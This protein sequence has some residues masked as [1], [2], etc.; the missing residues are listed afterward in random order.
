M[1]GDVASQNIVGYNTVG[2][3]G[4]KNPGIGA[5]FIPV[6]AT[7][8]D[9]TTYKLKDIT[10]S[11]G[12]DIMDIS[13]E[14]IQE[15]SPDGSAVVGRYTYLSKE[16]IDAAY[17]PAQREAMYQYIGWWDWDKKG[18]YIGDSEH[19]RNEHEVAV[20]T[21]FLAFISKNTRFFTSSGE[22]PTEPTFIGNNGHKNPFFINYL[23]VTLKL[24]QITMSAG[25]D[26]M[27]ISA[28][29][30]Q[31]LSPDGSAVIGRYTFLSKEYIDAAYKPAQREAMYPYIGWWD[32]DKKGTYIGDS[33]HS[34]D[35]EVVNPSDSFLGFLSKGTRYVNFPSALD[36]E[37]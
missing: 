16:Y 18:T 29:Y 13:A 4:H 1:F 14:Y 9:G 35:N 22:V 20:G 32:W 25:K 27:D 31:V 15:L 10:V 21:A 5:T 12:K 24:K 33:E 8:A 26:I 17:K 7:Q 2:N 30:I 37:D 34:R 3:N 6:G 23:P 28:E 19:D 11:A 36:V